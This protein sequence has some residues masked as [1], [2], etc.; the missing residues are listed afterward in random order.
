MVKVTAERL[1]DSQVLL[2]IEVEPDRVERA[3]DRAYRNLANRVTVPGFRKG[4]APRQILERYLGKDALLQEGI[5]AAVQDAYRDALKEIDLHPIAKPDVDVDEA[6]NPGEPLHFRVTVPVFPTVDLDDYRSVRLKPLDVEVSNDQINRT[7]DALREQHAQWAPVDRPVRPGDRLI[8]D[9]T[10]TVGTAPRL[11]GPGG[12]ALLRT[13]GGVVVI[14]EKD[15]EGIVGEELDARVAPGFSEKIVTLLPG[16]PHEFSLTLPSD[17]SNSEI[18][19]K[20]ATFWVKVDEVKEKQLPSIDDEFARLVGNVETLL[21]LREQIREELRGRLV[22]E[23]RRHFEESVVGAVVDRATV[24]LPAMLVAREQERF[25]K[26]LEESLRESG[27][28]MVDYLRFRRRS[29]AELQEELRQ[30]AAH[31]LRV[32]LVLDAVADA[33]KIEVTPD[34]VTTEIERI[35]QQV[36]R[37]AEA[38]QRPLAKP[39]QQAQVTDFLRTRKTMARLVE[40]AT[41][42][43][44]EVPAPAGEAQTSEATPP[45]EQS[46]WTVRAPSPLPVGEEQTSEVTPVFLAVSDSV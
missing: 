38:G 42:P 22:L 29:E 5:D 17:H 7:L 13:E 26:R 44:P 34:E 46:R 15:L 14:D 23:A 40:I 8:I 35:N 6:Y 2:H 10:G 11:Y 3:L 16:Q 12:E 9:V 39:E 37:Q 21:A 19:G 4:K 18:A 20:V 24:D 28:T 43:E 31:N 25:F 45:H 32:S 30:Q 41:S 36:P 27:L 1:Q 33:E